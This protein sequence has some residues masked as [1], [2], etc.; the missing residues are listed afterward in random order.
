MNRNCLLPAA[1]VVR[2][3]LY[4]CDVL[5]WRGYS[6]V[7][8][9]AEFRSFW[10]S[11]KLAEDPE[12]MQVR[13]EERYEA[14]QVK[15]QGQIRRPCWRGRK[16]RGRKGRADDGEGTRKV[17]TQVRTSKDRYDTGEDEQGDTTQVRTQG[18]F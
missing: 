6:L 4:I 12:A 14:T 9:A 1:R 16:G 13:L 2:S 10:L 5:V 18:K 17:S 8:C 3:T 11:T 7:E 15:V